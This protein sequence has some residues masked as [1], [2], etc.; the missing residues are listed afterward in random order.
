MR[1]TFSISFGLVS[2]SVVSFWSSFTR[3][4]V[5]GTEKWSDLDKFDFEEYVGTKQVFQFETVSVYEDYDI[6]EREPWEQPE[7]PEVRERP[8]TWAVRMQYVAWA[9]TI[10]R[11]EEEIRAATPN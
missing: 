8:C 2:G 7:E 9:R 11:T 4:R 3:V 5:R 6:E 10:Y 1:H